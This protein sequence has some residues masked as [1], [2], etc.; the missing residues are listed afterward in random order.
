MRA[1]QNKSPPPPSSNYERRDSFPNFNWNTKREAQA[2]ARTGIV[3][4]ETLIITIPKQLR[5]QLGRFERV[6][7][8]RDVSV[9]PEADGARIGQQ[10]VPRPGS[11]P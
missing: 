10:R 8:A 6:Q 5:I 3:H 7:L 4:I 2:R 9:S 1:E 11:H